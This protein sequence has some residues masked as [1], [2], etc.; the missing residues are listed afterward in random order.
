VFSTQTQTPTAPAP[1]TL[2]TIGALVSRLAATHAELWHEEDRARSDDDHQVARA[3]R[4]VD[5]LNQRRNDLVERIDE[6]VLE[7]VRAA[8]GDAGG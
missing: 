2:D 6:A 1:A 5:R 3:K 7:A 8:R 4:A